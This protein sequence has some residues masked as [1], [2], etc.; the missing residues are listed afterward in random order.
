M[1]Y[2]VHLKHSLDQAMLHSDRCL[3]I[4]A[5]PTGADFWEGSWVEYPDKETAL[6]ALENSGASRQTPCPLCKP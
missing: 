6:D 4:P 1:G 2:W 3:E 5:N